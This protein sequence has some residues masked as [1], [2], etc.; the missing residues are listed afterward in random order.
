[1]K[2]LYVY[3]LLPIALLLVPMILPEYVIGCLCSSL[4]VTANTQLRSTSSDRLSI[5]PSRRLGTPCISYLAARRTKTAASYNVRHQGIKDGT[6][7]WWRML[8]L[9][10]RHCSMFTCQ[11][12]DA[13]AQVVRTGCHEP[14]I[15]AR[16]C[17]FLGSVADYMYTILQLFAER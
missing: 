16:L 6:D 2:D 4:P 10:S 1:M 13:T 14:A 3:I 11:C 17:E 8:A 12:R 7:G 9:T 5:V 15:S